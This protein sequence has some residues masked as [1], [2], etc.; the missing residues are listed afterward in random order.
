MSPLVTTLVRYVTGLIQSSYDSDV[1]QRLQFF[2]NGGP[3]ESIRYHN[4]SL[5]NLPGSEFALIVLG[6]TVV[7]FAVMFAWSRK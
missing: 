6:Y 7:M 3:M 4:L 2:W 5:G 1:A